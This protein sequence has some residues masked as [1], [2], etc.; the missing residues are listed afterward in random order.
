MQALQASSEHSIC[1]AVRGDDGPRAAAILRDKFADALKAG[2]L[3]TVDCL[4]EYCVLAA[5]GERMNRR[6]EK[7]NG[8]MVAEVRREGV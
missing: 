1:F 7:K 2:R 5:V 6:L 8:G 3:Q 4:S